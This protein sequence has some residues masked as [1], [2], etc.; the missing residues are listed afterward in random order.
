LSQYH[1]DLRRA[2]IADILEQ[3]DW[4]GTRGTPDFVLRWEQA[5]AATALRI[6]DSPL[7]GAPCHFRDPRLADIR[8]MPVEGFPRHLIF[9]RFHDN[10]VSVLR[11]LHGARDLES[12]FSTSPETD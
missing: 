12:I 5:I 7:I 2:A 4:Y 8:R 6:V 9:Y 10:R 1:L 11:L 3:A